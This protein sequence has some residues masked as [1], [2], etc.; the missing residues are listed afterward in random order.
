MH[1]LVPFTPHPYYAG[2]ETYFAYMATHPNLLKKE[3]NHVRRGGLP[4]NQK[5]GIFDNLSNI[6]S[7]IQNSSFHRGEFQGFYV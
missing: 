3:K 6:P 4:T 1:K 7:N 2:R 5:K